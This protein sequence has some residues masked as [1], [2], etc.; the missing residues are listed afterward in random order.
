M[1]LWKRWTIRK[2]RT[3]TGDEP[4]ALATILAQCPGK[5]VAVDMV[6]NE[7]REVADS[8]YAL[9]AKIRERRLQNVAV[10]R[11]PDPAEPELVGLG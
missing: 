2:K 6:T 1:R 4:V 9:A 8:P 3:M 10:V 11:S 5:W 7:L